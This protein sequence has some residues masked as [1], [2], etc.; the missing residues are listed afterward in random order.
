MSTLTTAQLSKTV[1]NFFEKRR[2]LEEELKEINELISYYL[3][4]YHERLETDKKLENS[5]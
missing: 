4:L 2:E 5:L 3:N 1:S